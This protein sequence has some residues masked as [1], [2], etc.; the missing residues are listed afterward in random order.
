MKKTLKILAIILACVIFIFLIVSIIIK[1]VAN[2][3]FYKIDNDEIRSINSVVGKRKVTYTSLSIDSG[4]KTKIMTYKS[5]SA[6]LANEDI[7]NY[8]NYLKKNEGFYVT[9]VDPDNTP[10]EMAKESVEKGNIITISIKMD[11]SS[12]TLIIKKFEGTLNLK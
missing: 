9:K 6:S 2:S 12:Y 4:V 11:E 3:N 1:S 5:D 8:Y 7:N 10:I